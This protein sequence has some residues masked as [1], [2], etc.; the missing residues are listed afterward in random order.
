MGVQLLT[1]HHTIPQQFDPENRG[2]GCDFSVE[3]PLFQKSL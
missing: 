2:E 1:A 3:V